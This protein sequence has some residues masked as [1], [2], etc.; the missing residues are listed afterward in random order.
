M[1]EYSHPVSGEKIIGIRLGPGAVLHEFDRHNATSGTWAF[2]PNPG[3]MLDRDSKTTWVRPNSRLSPLTMNVL[4]RLSQLG[5]V[6]TD[7]G[8][9]RVIPTPTF[10]RVS[11][12]G[13]DLTPQQVHELTSH[14]LICR[15][16]ADKEIYR[17]TDAG[18]ELAKKYSN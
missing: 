5:F 10:K 12:V 15:D 1:Q 3:L 13:T 2:C 14:G 7:C 18:H 8:Y 16:Q 17:I 4:A 9:W 6:V 11:S